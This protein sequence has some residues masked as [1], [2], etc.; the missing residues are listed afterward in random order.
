MSLNYPL[1]Y[2]WMKKGQQKRITAFSGKRQYLH[3]IGAYNWLS[4]EVTCLDV[5]R[6]NSD[7]FITFL[8][9]ILV[10]TYPTQA[11]V[12]VMDNASYHYSRKVQ[13]ALSLFEHRVQ[14][15]WLPQY[16]PELN[17]IERFWLHLKSSAC[18]N[19]LYATLSSLR[20]A[21]S[22]LLALQ[23]EPLNPQRLLFSKDFR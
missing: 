2:C 19:K 6:K 5:E 11:I 1:R 7:T 23:N 18:A 16:C 9:K 17:L 20:D 10:E 14:I 4:D 3:L 12:I 21:V 22:H 15:L 13:A 8:E